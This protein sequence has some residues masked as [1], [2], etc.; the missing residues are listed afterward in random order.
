VGIFKDLLSGFDR[1]LLEVKKAVDGPKK[2]ECQV[3]EG[4]GKWLL[5]SAMP[6]V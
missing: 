1:K 4:A 5:W 6:P 2:D 3:G